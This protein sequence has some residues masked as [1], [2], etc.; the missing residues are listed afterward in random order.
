MIKYSLV[1]NRL[2]T[3]ASV[4]C[5]ARTVQSGTVSFEQFVQELSYGST[6]TV[7]DVRAVMEN[8]VRVCTENLAQ[9]RSV[10][11]GFCTL[12]STV[13]GPF[14]SLD[15]GF[16]EEK[17]WIKIQ[18]TCSPAF[19]K[20]VALSAKLSRVPALKSAP[21]LSSFENHS[22]S[23]TSKF[24]TNDLMTVRGEQLKFDK[25]MPEQ[26]I[27]LSGNGALLRVTEYSNVTA[28][29]VSFKVPAGLNPGTEYRIVLKSLFGTE[30]RSGETDTLFTAE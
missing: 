16:S 30:M 24:S 5:V 17:N 7:A 12:K 8:I 27:F 28:K 13:K 23:S 9:G 22:S 20:R 26:G 25:N 29:S 11:L 2:S 3:S 6:A 15:D 4:P 10:N 19:E 18:T 21:V 14:A 1:K